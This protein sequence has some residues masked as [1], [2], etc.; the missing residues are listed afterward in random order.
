MVVPVGYDNVR[1]PEQRAFIKLENGLETIV[2]H[3]RTET[4]SPEIGWVI[5]VPSYPEVTE[6][7]VRCVE[8]GSMCTLN[9]PEEV[10]L[11]DLL[12]EIHS[13]AEQVRFARTGG[14][15]VAV[16]V[17]VARATTGRSVVAVCGYHGWHDWYLAANLGTENA[18]GDHLLPG[19]SPAGVPKG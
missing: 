7:V 17:R 6:A 2:L 8:S 1:E 19:L 4:D 9:S 18:L 10:E 11:A 15:A 14:E 16:A 12:C 3:V 13:W 5:P